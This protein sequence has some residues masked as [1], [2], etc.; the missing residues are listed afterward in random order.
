MPVLIEFIETVLRTSSDKNFTKEEQ[1]ELMK[2][3][4]KIISCCSDNLVF[5][6]IF[7]MGICVISIRRSRN[8]IKKYASVSTSVELF[9]YCIF[10]YWVFY[11]SRCMAI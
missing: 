1:S 8:C 9:V 3:Y 6:P 4:W 11:P 7:R 2:C 10:T 5:R